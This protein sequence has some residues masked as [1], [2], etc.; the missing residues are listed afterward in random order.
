M[1]SGISFKMKQ[2]KVN[3]WEWFEAGLAMDDGCSYGW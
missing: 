3:G 1:L 2:D